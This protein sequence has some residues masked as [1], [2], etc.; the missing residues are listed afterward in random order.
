MPAPIERGDVA[1][2]VVA[3]LR[4][5]LSE[6]LPDLRADRSYGSLGLRDNT[7]RD[8]SHSI[9][10]LAHLN[11]VLTTELEKRAPMLE[12]II[13]TVCLIQSS[14]TCKEIH[15]SVTPEPWRATAA[16]F[17]LRPARPSASPEMAG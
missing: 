4:N 5:A 8:L 1:D 15:L 14:S 13:L 2:A 17:L 12:T 9:G 3:A 6:I 11:V 16:A 7:S 10:K